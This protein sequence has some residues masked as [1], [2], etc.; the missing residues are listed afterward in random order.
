MGFREAINFGL[1]AVPGYLQRKRQQE[2]DRR[3]ELMAEFAMQN[4]AEDN[5]LQRERFDLERARTA[6]DDSRQRTALKLQQDNQ[7]ANRAAM[8]ANQG[9]MARSRRADDERQNLQFK[10]RQ[11]RDKIGDAQTSR[12]Q[13]RLEQPP[14]RT[15]QIPSTLMFGA[16]DQQ[17]ETLEAYAQRLKAAGVPLTT[18]QAYFDKQG[19]SSE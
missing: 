17:G 11:G 15:V 13:S 19:L 18:A 10:Y 5:A 12:V 14:E 9:E 6:E 1:E 4:Q 7:Q 8:V 2:Q 3:A 16:G